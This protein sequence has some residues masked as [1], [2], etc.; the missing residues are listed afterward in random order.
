MQ[1]GDFLGAI[2][3]WTR[4]LE[5]HPNMPEALLSRAALSKQ[6][7]DVR[8]ALADLD[9]AVEVA[10]H[11][12]NAYIARAAVRRRLNDNKGAEEDLTRA[13]EISPHTYQAY[14]DRA[15]LRFAINDM[16]GAMNDYNCA[17]G[18]NPDLGKQASRAIQPQLAKQK[19]TANISV[20]EALSHLSAGINKRNGSNG[21]NN[22][23]QIDI[24]REP[25]PHQNLNQLKE[26]TAQ[27][28]PTNQTIT[29]KDLTKDPTHD[30]LK[31]RSQSH[32][33]PE[34]YSSLS[35]AQIAKLNN[36]AVSDI[37]N[38]KFDAAIKTL[39]G[40]I[41]AQPD[42]QQAKDNLVIAHNNFALDLAAHKPAEAIKHF[43][44]AL[45]L[46]PGQTSIRKNLSSMVRE[47]GM[48]PNNA[49]DR[50]IMAE[51][52]LREGD[53]EG[54]YV[55]ITEG[56]R[57]KNSAV[58]RKQMQMVL[59]ALAGESFANIPV[60][61]P[62]HNNQN[63]QPQATPPVVAQSPTE[64]VQP[65]ATSQQIAQT[66]IQPQSPPQQLASSAGQVPSALASMEQ[67]Q[68]R[69]GEA[70][71]ELPPAPVLATIKPAYTSVDQVREQVRA[72]E[73]VP[74]QEPV[75]IQ[76]QAQIQDQVHG[77]GQ[78]QTQEH[79]PEP[80][81]P[82]GHVNHEM[83]KVTLE[84]SPEEVLFMAR[85]FIAE[86]NY[87]DAEILLRKMAD[88]FRSNSHEEKSD[89]M[90]DTALEALSELYIRLGN[91]QKAEPTLKELITLRERNKGPNDAILGKTVIEYTQVL[92]L[93]GRNAEADHLEVKANT[94]LNRAIS[95]H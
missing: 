29:T 34:E 80:V 93:L 15:S 53:L 11:N 41:E 89:S 79:T 12:A 35:A 64:Q 22:G 2:D 78:T 74:V 67:I 68:V 46:E 62:A 40:L 27:T 86:R 65:P 54:A 21:A 43:R 51:G 47:L 7:G 49:D 60:Q 24:G 30:Y 33:A 83:I 94:I 69:P 25:L 87:I 44:A 1:H 20:D 66:A 88:H 56:L 91:Y 63:Q 31:T 58:L 95:A 72:Q 13:I 19:E 32:A 6:I 92:R 57:Y 17:Y 50:L 8:G 42:Y 71:D 4:V 39:N 90:L 85:Q 70:E 37:N 38:K 84:S 14:Y 48:Q 28:N 82:S 55:E 3:I 59:A 26:T 45:Y 18:I 61:E 10:P 77:T 73:Q 9:H 36:S 75:R 16:P 23:L 81:A 52:C 76:E 5:T